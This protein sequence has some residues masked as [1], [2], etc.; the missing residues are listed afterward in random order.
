MAGLSAGGQ[1]Y[2]SSQ[3]NWSTLIFGPTQQ[4]A[5]NPDWY[6]QKNP[7]TPF[8]LSNLTGFLVGNDSV[9]ITFSEVSAVSGFIE[10]TPFN[11]F[12][13]ISV[14]FSEI[15][16]NI[17][18]S[19]RSDNTTLSITE[20]S[21]NN[22]SSVRTD[23]CGITLDDASSIRWQNLLNDTVSISLS[24]V[25]INRLTLNRFDVVS[26]NFGETSANAVGSQRTDIINV[27]LI[28]AVT[29]GIRSN[30]SD[31]LNVLF[32]ESSSISITIYTP[33]IFHA[34]VSGEIA[35]HNIYGSIVG[36][37]V[38]GSVDNWTLMCENLYSIDLR[39]SI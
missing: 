11:V 35:G 13:S 32:T 16:T 37:R 10:V 26:V 30:L 28:D 24:E 31:S 19:S 34:D 29:L 3:Q 9:I 27:S 20:S 1:T 15:S 23:S 22:L 25:S 8:P 5:S 33:I 38:S 21:I 2:F 39:G 4:V 18:G 6:I 7:G 12:D 14:S 36:A 17:L